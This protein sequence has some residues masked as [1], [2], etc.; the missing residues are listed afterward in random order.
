MKNEKNEIETTGKTVDE[1]IE[2]G[3]KEL[4]ISKKDAEIKILDEGKPGLFGLMGFSPARI[5]ISAKN[6]VP[7]SKKTDE[8][9][10]DA[11]NEAQPTTTDFSSMLD[12]YPL[13]AKDSRV[14]DSKIGKITSISPIDYT[15]VSKSAE[16]IIKKMLELA[17][18]VV[19]VSTEVSHKNG[20]T[21]NVSCEDSPI[22]IGRQGQTI[23][24]IE[25]ILKLI[26]GKQESHGVRVSLDIDGYLEK[27]SEKIVK[28]AK[29]LEEYVKEKGEPIEIKLPAN[30]RKIIHLTLQNSEFVETISDGEGENR[31]I[32]I[33]PKSHS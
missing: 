2:K 33:R 21:F 4:K 18:F 30:E 1:A 28:K 22:L 6:G 11:S 15:V 13:S 25:Y 29:E 12:T 9:I 24:A 14:S 32:I 3:L 8:F 10:S 26:L 16:K 31:K 19:K 5:K 27:K 23:E 17:G 20:I 7:I